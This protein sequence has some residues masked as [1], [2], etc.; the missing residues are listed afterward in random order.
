MGEVSDVEDTHNWE[1]AFEALSWLDAKQPK[2]R[3][4]QLP[5]RRGRRLVVLVMEQGQ[6]QVLVVKCDR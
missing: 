6:S 5:V 1:L 3:T 2:G 4:R